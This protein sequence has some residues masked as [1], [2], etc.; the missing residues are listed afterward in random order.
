[1]LIKILYMDVKY[2]TTNVASVCFVRVINSIIQM[3]DY[4]VILVLIQIVAT[5]IKI[6][7]VVQV[8]IV[9][10]GNTILTQVVTNVANAWIIII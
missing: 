6:H 5:I 2:T 3:K 4:V 7:V 10:F 8:L 9:K 1:M